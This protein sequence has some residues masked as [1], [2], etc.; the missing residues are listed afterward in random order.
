MAT[1]ANAF[2]RQSDLSASLLRSTLGGGDIEDLNE[3]KLKRARPSLN[4][5]GASSWW[6]QSSESKRSPNDDEPR[7]AV[8][9]C[10]CEG[11]ADSRQLLSMVVPVC[12]VPTCGLFEMWLFSEWRYDTR[13]KVV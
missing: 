11:R 1:S 10:G 2:P 3:L 7:P 6:E 9:G 13:P 12:G 8:R 5:R 4:D